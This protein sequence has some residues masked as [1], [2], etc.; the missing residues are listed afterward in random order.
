VGAPLWGT[1]PPGYWLWHSP[2]MLLNR[3]AAELIVA[4]E[5]LIECFDG[6]PA[7]DECAFGTILHAA[8]YPLKGKVAEHDMTW[9]RRTKVD[10]D[11]PEVLL[12]P[13]ATDMGDIAGSGAFF[14][15]KFGPGNVMARFG[16]HR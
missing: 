4:N 13:S 1:V 5:N 15:R 6:A 9:S 14:A 3:E 16:L 7:P 12:N 10:P 8:G 2:W 11:R